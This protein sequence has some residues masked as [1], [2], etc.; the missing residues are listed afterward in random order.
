LFFINE[1]YFECVEEGHI[2]INFQTRKMTRARRTR[3]M[4]TKKRRSSS[5][6]R[7]MAKPILLSEILMQA[8]IMIVG[9][10]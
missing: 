3:K 2:I 5:K 9:I 6:E 1:K 8:P 10:S 7:R 4:M